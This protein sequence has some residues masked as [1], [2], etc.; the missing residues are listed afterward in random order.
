MATF[1]T[2]LQV[3]GMQLKTDGNHPADAMDIVN[4]DSGRVINKGL[5]KREYFAAMA[6]T[7]LLTRVPKRHG[8]ETDLGTLECKRIA[9]E[10]RIMADALIE[11]LNK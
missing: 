6:M 5:T 8:G 2:T 9:D 7:G 11:A 4:S 10:S 3:L 1:P